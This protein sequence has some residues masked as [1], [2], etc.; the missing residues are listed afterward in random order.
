MAAE[1]PQPRTASSKELLAQLGQEMQRRTATLEL[2]LARYQAIHSQLAEMLQAARAGE[3]GAAVAGSSA[4][5]HGVQNGH[6]VPGL[7]LT[8]GVP[9]ELPAEEYSSNGEG[10]S[11]AQ[12]HGAAPLSQSSGSRSTAV[13]VSESPPSRSSKS[14]PPAADTQFSGAEG[15]SQISYADALWQWAPREEAVP[16]TRLE[17]LPRRQ[18]QLGAA[19]PSRWPEAL[20]QRC[21]AAAQ[22]ADVSSRG[23]QWQ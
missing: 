20:P 16:M 18:H 8:P 19:E 7:P 11:Q 2:K 9:S 23:W 14:S 10:Y 3:E 12:E 17:D 22:P 4:N 21:G 1:A 5:G 6:V 13:G 15:A